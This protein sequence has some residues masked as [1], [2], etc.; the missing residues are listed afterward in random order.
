MNGRLF[1]AKRR[2]TVRRS[3]GGAVMFIV[4]MTLAVLASVGMYA[5]VAASIEIKTS[6]YGKQAAQTHYLAE[7]GMLAIAT[8]L[9]G[10]NAQLYLGLMTTPGTSDTACTS[11]VGVSSVSA[12]NLTKS[13]RRMGSAELAAVWGGTAATVASVG[14]WPSGVTTAGSFGP[15]PRSGDFYVELTD[16]A[17][18]A[19]PPGYDVK[20]GLCFAQFTVSSYGITRPVDDAMLD[21]PLPATARFGAWGLEQSRGRVTAGPVRCAQ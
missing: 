13:C 16:P 7:Y 4:A 5:L 20:L 12:Q 10:T 15:Y 11:L 21:V 8:G 9:N 3:S 1:H 19:A 14:K 18:A 6:G 17:N 2:A